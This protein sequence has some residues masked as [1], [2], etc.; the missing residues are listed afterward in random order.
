M[1]TALWWIGVALFSLGA[2][3]GIFL[4]LAA[5]KETGPRLTGIR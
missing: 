5:P 4:P 2:F 1:T 3:V